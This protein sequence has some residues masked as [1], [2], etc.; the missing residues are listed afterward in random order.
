MESCTGQ[1]IDFDRLNLARVR[2]QD[3]NVHDFA[4]LKE[5]FRHQPHSE[6]PER[7]VVLSAFHKFI[8]SSAYRRFPFLHPVLL[9]CTMETAYENRLSEFSPDVPSAR[10]CIFAFIAYSKFILEGNSSSNDIRSQGYIHE[11][12]YLVSEILDGQATLDGIQ[13]LLMVVS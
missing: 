9:P 7:D 5:R 2:K 8:S 13:A 12:Q 11:A 1:K 6:L 3:Q 4:S 10:A